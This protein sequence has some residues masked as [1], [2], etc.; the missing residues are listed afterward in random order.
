[1]VYNILYPF[2]IC[3][4]LSFAICTHNEGHYVSDLLE[5]LTK[6]ILTPATVASGHQ[7]EIVILDDYSDV[8]TE[9]RILA[10]HRSYYEFIHLH[11]H[12]LNGDFATHKNVLNSK[13]VGDWIL[14]LDADEWIPNHV[15]DLI[16]LI[17]EANP[18]VDAYWF[19]RINTVD[20]L[21]LE[22]VQQWRWLITPMEGFRTTECLDKTDE[23]YKLL[24]GHGLI[25]SEDNGVVVYDKPIV[26]WPDPQM[27]LY[28]NDANIRWV[29]AVH[30]HLAGYTNF[31][32]MPYE[33]QYAIRHFKDIQR[34]INQNKFYD[35]IK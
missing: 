11:Q 27:R 12:P 8:D 26:C 23:F 4:K 32:M 1:M 21:T 35:S 33:P 20:G 19:P 25:V 3:M 10:Y 15:I 28:K 31:T 29:G 24:S 9:Q 34:Q 22:H 14:N 18:L 6:Y 16:P 30:E 7:F 2:R 5:R 13:C 17:I